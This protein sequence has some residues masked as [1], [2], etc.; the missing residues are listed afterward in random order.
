M[1]EINRIIGSPD[2]R[3]NLESRY[4]PKVNVADN[5]QCWNWVSKSKHPFGYGRMTAGRKVNLK[6]HQIAWCLE[7]GEIP[8]GKFVCHSCDNP[9]CCNH[10]H[11]FLGSQL[12]NVQD[13]ISKGRNSPPPYFV[14]GSHP[15]SKL[16][17]A[18][19]RDIL[20]DKRSAP[21]I[22]KHYGV[23]AKTIYRVRW[24]A[25]STEAITGEEHAS[26]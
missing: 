26:T 2:A 12:Q 16:T 18:Q 11:L 3:E 22:A 20:N 5:D 6:A 8:E 15:R 19:T 1:R 13:C 24:S 17:D 10:N 21:A 4:W 9:S 7:N 14:G 23:S 25:K